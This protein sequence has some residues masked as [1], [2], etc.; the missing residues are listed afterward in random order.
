MMN[1]SSYKKFNVNS[2]AMS[3][4]AFLAFSMI[5]IVAIGPMSANVSYFGMLYAEQ[6][7]QISEEHNHNPKM[8]NEKTKK[9]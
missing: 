7:E 1:R 3:S 9:V 5:F 8:N 2:V 6:Q 4:K